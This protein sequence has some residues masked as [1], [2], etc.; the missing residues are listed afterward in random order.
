MRSHFSCRFL[1][2]SSKSSM[3]W[4]N[5]KQIFRFY[6]RVS[7]NTS[8]SSY[9]DISFPPL[10]L[11]CRMGFSASHFNVLDDKLLYARFMLFRILAKWHTWFM[12]FGIERYCELK[13]TKHGSCYIF[14]NYR[15]VIQVLLS[16][17][18]SLAL[19]PFWNWDPPWLKTWIAR[20]I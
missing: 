20:I 12:R 17:F 3:P 19:S 18:M 16:K 15:H 1:I 2:L 5:Q 8:M 10:T 9:L 13:F 7:L 14:S 6:S 4:E 11:V